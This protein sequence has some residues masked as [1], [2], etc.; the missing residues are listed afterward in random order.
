MPKNELPALGLLLRHGGLLLAAYFGIHVVTRM[1]V[2]STL[3]LDEAEQL[4]FARELEAGYGVQPPLYTWLQWFVFRFTGPTIFGLAL[5]KNLLLAATYA[6]TYAAARTMLGRRDMAL[7]A[8]ASL[9][10]LHQVAWEAQRDLSHSVLVT[11]CAAGLLYALVKTIRDGRPGA[12]AALGLFLGAGL[13]AKYSFAL[14]AVALLGA[15]AWLPETRARLLR[16]SLGITVAIAAAVVL[17]HSLWLL[18]HLDEVTLSVIHDLDGKEPL[19]VPMRLGVGWGSLLWALFQFLTPLWLV[20]GLVLWRR[21]RGAGC[22]PPPDDLWRRLMVRYGLL[23]LLGMTLLILFTES[24]Y[25]KTRWMLPYAYLAPIVFL[26]LL[27]Q[28]LT[29][30]RL[31]AF[32]RIAAGFALLVL[33]AMP[34]RIL[35][36]DI[37]DAPDEINAPVADI[38]AQL[39]LRGWNGGVLITDENY[40]AGTLQL[41]LPGTVV[42]DANRDRPAPDHLLAGRCGIILVWEDARL[43]SPPSPVLRAYGRLTGMAWQGGDGLTLEAPYAYSDRVFRVGAAHDGDAC[44]GPERSLGAGPHGSG[45]HMRSSGTS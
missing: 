27:H 1:L 4:L 15:A 11:A 44:V 45:H 35:L 18:H 24:A 34:A 20:Y 42:V 2:T 17:P 37:L 43:A 13:V 23:V 12:F 21:P 29:P 28:R 6:F 25:F 38:A 31:E 30:H 9:L 19:S 8:A 32:A 39:S 40:L 7:V 22:A 14:Y 33:V 10:F 16:P 3:G 5:L 41:H 36:Y 26:L